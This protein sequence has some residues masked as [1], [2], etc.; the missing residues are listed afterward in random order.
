M[1]KVR[2][3]PSEYKKNGFIYK[4]IKR[5]GMVAMFEVLTKGRQNTGYEVYLIRTINVT[6]YLKKRNPQLVN[7]EG[8]EVFPSNEDFG[9]Y[10]WYFQSKTLADERYL[11]L[12]RGT[13]C[14]L[15]AKSV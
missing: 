3:I 9:A 1:I 11:G 6:E 10:G 7:F 5:E 2:E 8:L 12:T 15:N 14:S 4:S 13:R